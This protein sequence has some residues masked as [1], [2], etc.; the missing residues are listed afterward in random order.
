MMV[1][2][3]VDEDALVKAA[4]KMESVKL[5]LTVQQLLPEKMLYA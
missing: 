4:D 3:E 5:S 1:L 2:Q